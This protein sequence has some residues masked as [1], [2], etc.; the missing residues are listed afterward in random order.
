[1]KGKVKIL[2]LGFI[3]CLMPVMLCSDSVD[4]LGVTSYK[5]IYGTLRVPDSTHEKTQIMLHG[6]FKYEI[7]DNSNLYFSY[8]VKMF[9]DILE[10]S[11]P[12]YDINHNP[13]LF[14]QTTKKWL[15]FW[16][17]HLT[18]TKVGYEHLSNG[19]DNTSTGE[20]GM[21]KRSRSLNNINAEF[22]FTLDEHWKISP[23]IYTLFS[24]KDN[25]DIR[26]YYGNA[27]VRIQYK[28][29]NFIYGANIRGNPKTGK[30]RVLLDF[31][32]P[33]TWPIKNSNM[34][35]YAE[36]FNG[37]GESLLDYD[38]HIESFRIGMMLSRK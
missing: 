21:I 4:E 7:F 15:P 18:F 13:E 11:S 26:D 25:P 23:K 37:Y 33:A 17:K 27:D 5:G 28:R 30:G 6:G 14:W 35:Y 9:W 8:R 24:I 32:T 16:K 22:D 2:N 19:V 34:F 29:Y 31:S 12:F 10:K 3:F 20:H 38:K 1:M 36:Y